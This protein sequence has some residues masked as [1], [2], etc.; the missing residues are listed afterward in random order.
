MNRDEFERE[1]GRA[2]RSDPQTASSDFTETVL[3][4]ARRGRRRRLA[5]PARPALAAAALALA[6]VAGV[7]VWR[8]VDTV[9]PGS[10]DERARQELLEEYRQIE[11]ELGEIRRMA[12]ETDPVLYLGGDEKF[13]LVY[14]LEGHE[15]STESGVRPASGPGRG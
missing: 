4:R 2:L 12:R 1:L 3:E 10:S 13:D 8:D 6:V 15:P 9:S 14:D 11:A 5:L 7:A